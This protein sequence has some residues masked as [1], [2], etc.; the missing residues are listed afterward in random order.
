MLGV[1]QS[2]LAGDVELVKTDVVQEHVDAA[3]VISRDVDLLPEEAVPDRIPA[4]D[5]LDLQQKR[6]RAAGRVIDLVDLRLAHRPQSGQ[7]NRD[8]R[9]GE[10]FAAG[11]ARVGGI[12]GHEIFIGIAECVDLMI[13]DRAEVHGRNAVEQLGQALVPLGDGR[14]QLVAVDIEII[15]QAGE[16]AFGHAALGRILDMVEHLFKL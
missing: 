11:L 8:I 14:A 12:H 10:E 7:K 15:E 13:L 16:V 2:I 6:A 4:E 5:F 9:R 1:Q 3:E